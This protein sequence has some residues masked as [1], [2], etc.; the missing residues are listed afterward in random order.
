MNRRALGQQRVQPSIVNHSCVSGENCRLHRWVARIGK[1]STERDLDNVF[2]IKL[3]FIGSYSIEK[4]IKRLLKSGFEIF[5]NVHN[6][7][8][9]R[10]IDHAVR[11]INEQMEIVV[12]FQFKWEFHRSL[13][14]DPFGLAFSSIAR[15]GFSM[16][17]SS[18]TLSH[19]AASFRRWN[20]RTL[21][22][23]S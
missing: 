14:A 7:F 22:G 2:E 12:K 8:N 1:A 11:S 16:S 3:N 9:N 15:A 23:D 20:I 5:E 6:F 10:L 4:S 19:F 17:R 21:M 18:A 13:I